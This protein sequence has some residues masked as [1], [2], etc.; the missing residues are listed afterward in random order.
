MNLYWSDITSLCIIWLSI[1]V[2][3]WKF[4]IHNLKSA[5]KNETRVTPRLSSIMIGKTNDKGYLPHKLLL[6]NRQVSTLCKAFSS[7]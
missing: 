2:Q 3:I 4:L 7:D 1:T 6:T 5:R